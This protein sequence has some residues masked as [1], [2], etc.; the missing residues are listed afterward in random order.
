MKNRNVINYPRLKNKKIRKLKLSPQPSI[1]TKSFKISFGIHRMTW[2]VLGSYIDLI[3]NLQRLR[4]ELLLVIVTVIH[5]FLGHL[6]HSHYLTSWKR[7][8]WKHF[9]LKRIFWWHHFFHFTD[10][11][12]WTG[13]T[14]RWRILMEDICI[15]AVLR[16]QPLFSR[17]LPASIFNNLLDWFRKHNFPN[18]IGYTSWIN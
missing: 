17:R 9:P 16:M 12:K 6:V 15:V 1:S 3:K 7:G 5:N 18:T 13:W 11:E 2:T 4:G 14:G 10:V 8:N